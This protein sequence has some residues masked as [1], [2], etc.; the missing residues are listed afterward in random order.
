MKRHCWAFILLLVLAA[1]AVA[2]SALPSPSHV[3]GNADGGASPPTGRTVARVNGVALTDVDLMR[4]MLVMFPYA[5][6]HGGKVPQTLEAGIRKGA[7]QM[8][9][10]EELVYQE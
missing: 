6:Q 9:E 10:F 5:R 4:E 3:S 2:Q 8:I 1:A 7:L